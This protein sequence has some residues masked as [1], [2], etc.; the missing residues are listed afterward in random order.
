MKIYKSSNNIISVD[1]FNIPLSL[2][3]E[4][5]KTLSHLQNREAN[6]KGLRSTF[7]SFGIC[8]DWTGGN[9]Y[10]YFLSSNLFLL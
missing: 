1:K 8:E 6:S 9:L 2:L 3:D 5:A 4:V 7:Y 10:C